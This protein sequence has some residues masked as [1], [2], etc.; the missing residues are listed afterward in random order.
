MVDGSF[1]VGS[2]DC[3]VCVVLSSGNLIDHPQLKDAVFLTG[4]N[5][6]PY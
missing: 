5:F 4:I 6:F 3:L 1:K 2:E